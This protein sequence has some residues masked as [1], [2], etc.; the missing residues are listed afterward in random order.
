MKYNRQL[1]IG[2]SF[3]GL[4]L[5]SSIFAPLLLRHDPNALASP[6]ET[7]HA[8]PSFEH[9]FGTD[10]FG[11]DVFTRVLYG[12]RISLLIALAVVIC[13]VA[14]G[15]LYG[16]I[17]GYLGGWWDQI[18]MRVVDALLAFPVVFLA[19]TLMA[20]FGTG[21]KWL[22]II[23]I[24]SSWMDVARVVRAEVLSLK[25]RPFIFKARAAGLH[26]PRILFY[27]LLP[28]A[29]AT[30][31]AA[32]ILRV[33][34]VILLESA[35]SFLGLGAQPPTASW[36]AILNDGKAVFATAWWIT[37]FP[38]LAIVTAVLSFNLIGEGLRSSQ[39]K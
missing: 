13:A 9:W 35:L 22:I 31:L 36:G 23:L 28:N 39:S 19:V 2:F 11:R 32:A 10:Q 5:T 38:G 29:F 3:L 33:A 14:F 15:A 17:A 20:V 16:A 6:A 21:L 12:G 7:R 27:H 26:A 1:L 30:V 25:Q 24:L 4:M 37:T 8:S 18:F 34:E